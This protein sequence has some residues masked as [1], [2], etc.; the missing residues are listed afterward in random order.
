MT[1]AVDPETRWGQLWLVAV[2]AILVSA[3]WWGPNAWNVVHYTDYVDPYGVVLYGSVVLVACLGV[4]L[5][6]RV[7][8]EVVCVGAALFVGLGV[9]GW[10]IGAGVAASLLSA[11]TTYCLWNPEDRYL[12]NQVPF[13]AHWFV[14]IAVGQALWLVLVIFAVAGLL[15][16]D[17]MDVLRGTGR[18]HWGLILVLFLAGIWTVNSWNVIL[19]EL[20]LH[21]AVPSVDDL[22]RRSVPWYREAP[23]RY[24][25]WLLSWWMLSFIV[26]MSGVCGLLTVGLD[27]WMGPLVPTDPRPVYPF[28]VG[29]VLGSLV[30]RVWCATMKAAIDRSWQRNSSTLATT[31]T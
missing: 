1:T 29:A 19:R 18:M 9:G 25:S 3:A 6:L 10:S 20:V 4:A 17:A 2:V 22:A 24:S 8:V 15:C 14:L 12:W 31:T 23:S 16:T 13:P 21:E 11:L 30:A 27:L 7:G 28:S 26:W 5:I